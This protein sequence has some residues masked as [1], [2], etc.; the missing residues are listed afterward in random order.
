MPRKKERTDSLRADLLS[1]AVQVLE[2]DGPGAVRAR[3]VAS[4]AGTSTAALYELFGD[5]AGLVRSIFLEGFHQL[6]VRLEEVPSSDDARADVLGLLVASRDFAIERPMLFEVMF[7]RPFAEFEP[8]PDD[9]AVAADIYRLVVA[10]V[11]R[12]LDGEGAAVDAVDVSHSLV[13]ANRGLVAA[14]LAG[15]AGT[16]AA[17]VD[18]RWNLAIGGLLD[19]LVQ[20]ARR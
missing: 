17:S 20:Q 4:V 14:E 10:R 8:G 6:L 9:Q 19:G 15:M 1:A 2:R 18:R 7:A 5:K 16:S 3:Q 12:W 13:A 11:R